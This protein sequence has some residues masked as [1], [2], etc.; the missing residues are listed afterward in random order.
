MLGEKGVPSRYKGPQ[1]RVR[2]KP[3]NSIIEKLE[4]YGI[5]ELA[6]SGLLAIGRGAKSISERVLK[7]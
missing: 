5:K 1:T 6:Q 7:N 4:P 2:A 3:H